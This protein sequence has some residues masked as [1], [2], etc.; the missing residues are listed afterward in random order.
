M[1][2]D[3]FH[4]N[5][6]LLRLT[7]I[8]TGALLCAAGIVLIIMDLR[9]ESGSIQL[10]LPFLTGEI[11]VTYVGL[12]VIFVGAVLQLSALLKKQS[13]RSKVKDSSRESSLESLETRN[14]ELEHLLF[15]LS[16][17]PKVRAEVK[18]ILAKQPFKSISTESIRLEVRS[19]QGMFAGR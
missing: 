19:D 5:V 6:M 15:L 10:E 14:K 9:P 11:S 2:S 18:E 8:I 3:S 1:I 7:V 13:M 17:N 4:R 16:L 12:F